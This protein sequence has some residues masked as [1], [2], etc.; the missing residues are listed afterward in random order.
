[1]KTLL[2]RRGYAIDISIWTYRVQGWNISPQIWVKIRKNKLHEAGEIEASADRNTAARRIYC[3]MG[4]W[5]AFASLGWVEIK[6]DNRLHSKSVHQT[7]L[8]KT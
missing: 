3:D 5:V 6:S 7:T 1:M 8:I 4:R 2:V